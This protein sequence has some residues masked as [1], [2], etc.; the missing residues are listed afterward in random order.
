M[1][2]N[3][4]PVLTDSR[5]NHRSQYNRKTSEIK[6]AENPESILIPFSSAD[7]T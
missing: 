6:P 7:S 3:T 5:T 2:Y 1:S 4:N